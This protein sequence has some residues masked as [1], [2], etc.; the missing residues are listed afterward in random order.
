MDV[1]ITN[2]ID[3]VMGRMP[4]TLSWK[5]R[6]FSYDVVVRILSEDILHFVMI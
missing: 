5:L 4:Y 1:G 6:K 3:Y 2:V